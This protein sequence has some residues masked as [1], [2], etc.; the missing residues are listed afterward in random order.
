ME[1]QITNDIKLIAFCGLYCAAC[2]SYLK[3][4]C[5]GCAENEKASWCKIRS[6]CLENNYK[7]CTD[8]K[9]YSNVMDCKKYNNFISKIIG[10]IFRSNR[11]ACIDIIKEK[12]YEGFASYMTGNKMMTIKK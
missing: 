4:K 11:A 2:P 8:C 9:Q 3:E 1:K 5:P 7:S 10:V 12:G 6:C